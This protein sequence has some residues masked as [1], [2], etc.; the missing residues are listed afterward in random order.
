MCS[1]WKYKRSISH[2]NNIKRAPIQNSALEICDT[3]RYTPGV[4]ESEY[5]T[6]PV[7]FNILAWQL[8]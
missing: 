2:A 1:M 5:Q 7:E 4:R 3:V 8:L 6:E